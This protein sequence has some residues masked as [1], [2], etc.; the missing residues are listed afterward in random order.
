MT[1]RLRCLRDGRVVGHDAVDRRLADVRRQGHHR[2]CARFP[3]VL[4]K[5]Q[6]RLRAGSRDVGDHWH[7]T[8]CL[9]DRAC[10]HLASLGI[11]ENHE[12]AGERGNYQAM[13]AAA[14]AEIH[15]APQ[16]IVIDR[17]SGCAGRNGIWRTGMMPAR[18]IADT[19]RVRLVARWN[20]ARPES[21]RRSC[22]HRFWLQFRCQ[23]CPAV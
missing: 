8:R 22:R 21:R 11:S 9:F 4:G 20:A 19:G 13:D 23:S 3:R 15:F 10:H 14:D 12:F 2:G 1:G 5:L 18:G 17:S 16:R 6:R 7:T